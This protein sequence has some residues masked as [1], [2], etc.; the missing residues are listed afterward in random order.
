MRKPS[1]EA[2]MPMK[3]A[4]IS[5]KA[6]I[7]EDKLKD[8]FA[9][10]NKL[11]L[12]NSV[13]HNL[14]IL[15]GNFS[16]IK[17]KHLRG[18]FSSEEHIINLNKIRDS[19]LNLI[20]D[21]IA[22]LPAIPIPT[23]DPKPIK[24]DIHSLDYAHCLRPVFSKTLIHELFKRRHSLNL[25]GEDGTGKGRQLDDIKVLCKQLGVRAAC[26]NLKDFRRDYE[27]FIKNIAA[28]LG[29]DGLQVK[30]IKGLLTALTQL[31]ESHFL[32]MIDQLAVLNDYQSNDK[33]Y[34]SDF[35]NSLNYLKNNDNTQLF[36][37]SKEWL[38]TVCFGGE[39]SLLT[40]QKIE[41][42][43]LKDMEMEAEICRSCSNVLPLHREWLR[44]KVRD[45]TNAYRCLEALLL[46]VLS[47]YDEK[48]F[49]EKLLAKWLKEL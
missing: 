46:K 12:D 20:D 39:T 3:E 49:S 26:V 31:R 7:S 4:L 36:C 14:T 24:I 48:T 22:E 19:F 43:I 23:P 30:D 1:L 6:L 11:N 38:Q 28:Q 40:L 41:T 18:V 5:I 33:R 27:L 37:A 13:K 25:I 32:I 34:N 16:H 42:P 8:A 9:E 2:K 44:K 29:L 17:T 35:V 45:K 10:L 47:H 15:E 21:L